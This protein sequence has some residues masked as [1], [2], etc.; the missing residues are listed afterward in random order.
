VAYDRK[1]KIP[2]YTVE[3]LYKKTIAEIYEICASFSIN[4]IGTLK[5]HMISRV[6]KR[7]MHVYED[8]SEA[9]GLITYFKAD[10]CDSGAQ[11]HVFYKIFFDA[12]DLSDRIWNAH[13]ERH[14]NN[15]R[16]SKFIL[17]S[18][19]IGVLNSFLFDTCDTKMARSDWRKGLINGFFDS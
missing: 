5:K 4:R 7:V 15:S 1:P 8:V 16:K 9:E 18:L 2:Q 13:N 10:Y 6:Y 17:N 11:F 14:V 12:I 3:E 19:R